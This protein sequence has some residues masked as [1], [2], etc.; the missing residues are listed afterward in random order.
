M[1]C[2][3]MRRPSL[4]NCMQPHVTSDGWNI[5]E[6]SDDSNVTQSQVTCPGQ[7]EGQY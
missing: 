2:E 4:V 1:S 7:L 6:R 5:S 3:K